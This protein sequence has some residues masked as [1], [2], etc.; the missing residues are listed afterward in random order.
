MTTPATYPTSFVK[1]GVIT[2]WDATPNARP[3]AGQGG[4]GRLVSAWGTALISA[5]Q[6]TTAATRLVRIPSN[7]IVKT[8]KVGFDLNGATVTTLT[9]VIGLLFSD[10]PS[11]GTSAYQ[12]GLGAQFSSAC[13]AATTGAGFDLHTVGSNAMVDVTYTAAV[14]VS[15]YTDGFYVPSASGMPIWLAI[16]QGGPAPQTDGAWAGWGATSLSTSPSYQLASDPGC[17]F[18]I[19]WMPTTISSISKAL[20]MTC[21]CTYVEG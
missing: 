10:A 12:Q 2:G 21:E 3:S 1:S 15:T 8:V 20:Q 13:F 19:Y 17:Y 9:G 7:A 6:A 4:P 11:D 16:T 5:T 18:D 14:G